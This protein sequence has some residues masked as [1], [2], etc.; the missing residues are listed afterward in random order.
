M[1]QE[2]VKE[3]TDFVYKRMGREFHLNMEL[4]LK[5]CFDKEGEF[6]VASLQIRFLENDLSGELELY[7]DPRDYI[8]ELGSVYYAGEEVYHRDPETYYV[9]W[10]KLSDIPKE[11]RYK[12]LVFLGF[13]N[14]SEE[15][16]GRV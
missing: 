4:W 9:S 10:D 5:I 14:I 16:K 7:V 15:I 8:D 6:S 1:N 12:I 2:L 3:V 13:D 11:V